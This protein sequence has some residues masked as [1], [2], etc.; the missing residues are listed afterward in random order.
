MRVVVKEFSYYL[1]AIGLAIV[2]SIVVSFLN[3]LIRA[4]S[5]LALGTALLDSG[6][7][8]VLGSGLFLSI[9]LLAVI[10]PVVIVVYPIG[11]IIKYAVLKV[12]RARK[13]E[14]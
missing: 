12:W 13:H 5:D 3:P 11:I 6:N 8:S 14:V 10:V 9:L 7:F 1:A 2:F 4:F